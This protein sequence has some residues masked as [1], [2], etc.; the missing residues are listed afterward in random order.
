MSMNKLRPEKRE[1]RSGGVINESSVR[2]PEQVTRVCRDRILHPMVSVGDHSQRLMD[3]DTRLISA[4][5]IGTQNPETTISFLTDLSGRLANQVQVLSDAMSAM[6]AVVANPTVEDR[7]ID[8]I[9]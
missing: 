5:G 7:R 3:T 4:Y 2:D 6:A 8:W 9:S 1:A